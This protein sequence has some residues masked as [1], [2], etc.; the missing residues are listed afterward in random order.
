MQNTAGWDIGERPTVRMA[1][2][3]YPIHAAPAFNVCHRDEAELHHMTPKERGSKEEQTRLALRNTSGW[4]SDK[5][6]IY[7][8]LGNPE[9]LPLTGPEL[10]GRKAAEYAKPRVV[11]PDK[12]FKKGSGGK[13]D[14]DLTHTQLFIGEPVRGAVSQ[15]CYQYYRFEL[16]KQVNLLLTL[17]SVNGDPDLFVS[18]EI[19]NPRQEPNE[20][21]WRG[22][23]AGD[24]VVL[25]DID[26]PRYSLGVSALPSLPA[27]SPYSPC[28][29]THLTFP[30]A[31]VVRPA[32]APV[33]Q[34][35]G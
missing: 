30:F 13:G 35:R 8:P 14:D 25:I 27:H 3:E 10:R 34:R 28:R 15:F 9:A 16:H 24:D 29:P 20:H 11:L 4:A 22:A 31:A 26:H 23:A 18:N 7:K 2:L 33:A 6:E 19:E 32:A 21:T 12:R 5:R 1:Y 17:K